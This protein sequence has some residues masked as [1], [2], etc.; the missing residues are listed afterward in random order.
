MLTEFVVL[1]AAL[2]LQHKIPAFLAICAASLVY[3]IASRRS[4]GVELPFGRAVGRDL[5]RALI[6][7]RWVFLTSSLIVLAAMGFVAG[8]WGGWLVTV[9]TGAAVWATWGLLT[10]GR[11]HEDSGNRYL[12]FR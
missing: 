6:A 5:G 7:C 9:V 12:G 2:L 8:Q 11:Q 3:G 10:A 4:D 1:M